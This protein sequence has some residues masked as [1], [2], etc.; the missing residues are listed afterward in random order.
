MLEGSAELSGRDIARAIL[1]D[2]VEQGDIGL[3]G[4]LGAL[5]VLGQQGSEGLV[6]QRLGGELDALRQLGVVHKLCERRQ[7]NG[8]YR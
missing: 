8:F 6:V 1:V 4:G 5:V 7:D 3:I 2:G